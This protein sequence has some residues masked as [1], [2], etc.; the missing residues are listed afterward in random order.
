MNRVAIPFLFSHSQDISLQYASLL[1]CM[2]LEEDEMPEVQCVAMNGL[3]DIL[4][5]HG[6]LRSSESQESGLGISIDEFV[7]GLNLYIFHTNEALQNVSCECYC[8][9]FIFDKIRSILCLSN[10]LLLLFLNF[11]MTSRLFDSATHR[12]KLHQILS[13]F[14]PSFCNPE[15]DRN[16][17]FL[18]E[19]VIFTL[20]GIAEAGIPDRYSMISKIGQFFILLMTMD[21]RQ[22]EKRRFIVSSEEEESN[23]QSNNEEN[24]GSSEKERSK[25]YHRCV[26]VLAEKIVELCDSKYGLFFGIR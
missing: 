24:K 8:K 16:C 2:V 13:V 20:K 7:E 1:L 4:I 5:T 19:A 14:F 21:L 18:E 11:A 23:D 10:L 17:L 15:I 12:F 26:L 6:D 9:L 22:S 3:T 25:E